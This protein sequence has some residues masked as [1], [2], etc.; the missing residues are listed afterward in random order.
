MWTQRGAFFR[1]DVP[2]VFDQ[3]L[4]LLGD[5]ACVETD[6]YLYTDTDVLF[7]QDIDSCDLNKPSFYTISGD[8]LREIMTPSNTGV[9][10]AD[11][12]AFKGHLNDIVSYADEIKWDFE[13]MDQ[14][15]INKYVFAKNLSI[16]YLHEKFNWKPYWGHS[17]DAVIVHFHG[18]KPLRCLPCF[19]EHLGDY[20]V[21]CS[22]LC[23]PIYLS[24]LDMIPDG[25]KF[26]KKMAEFIAELLAEDQGNSL[27]T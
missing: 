15:L 13:A 2:I 3:A 20:R 27:F 25:G 19:L 9:M 16:P 7:L 21:S 22:D 5:V 8:N 1:L 24:L 17:E 12:H 14:G 18:P 23:Y 10:Y 26:Y 6:Y 11:R 4:A